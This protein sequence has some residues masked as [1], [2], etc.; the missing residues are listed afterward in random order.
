MMIKILITTRNAI[1][2]L[3]CKLDDKALINEEL[4]RLSID[5]D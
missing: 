1:E 5:P 4:R 2:W 3:I